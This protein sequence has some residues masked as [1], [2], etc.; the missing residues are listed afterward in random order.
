MSWKMGAR[1]QPEHAR[2]RH[3]S[4][5][6]L[7]SS[8]NDGFGVAQA[9]LK[10][11]SS[12]AAGLSRFYDKSRSFTNFD[13]VATLAAHFGGRSSKVLGKRPVGFALKPA[14][15]RSAPSSPAHERTLVPKPA[16]CAVRSL[17]ATSFAPADRVGNVQAMCQAFERARVSED[18]Y[19][20]QST[21]STGNET[22]VWATMGY[23]AAIEM[24]ETAAQPSGAV[25]VT[26]S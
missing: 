7:S 24:A 8:K 11:N 23:S 26:C 15:C 19:E 21:N 4:T 5:S 16:A 18:S 25:G 13:E 3:T 17:E 10:R 20:E 2:L 1:T 9:I 22:S 6:G 12:R 14:R